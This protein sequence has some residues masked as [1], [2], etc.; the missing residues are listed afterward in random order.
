M[1]D[2]IRAA[3]GCR[4]EDIYSLEEQVLGELIEGRYKLL[5]KIGVGSMGAVFEAESLITKIKVAIKLINPSLQN[6]HQFRARFERE[7]FVAENLNSPYCAE[8]LEFG[9]CEDGRLFL[10]MELLKG[11]SIDA[12]LKR[13]RTFGVGKALYFT[14]QVLKGLVA[15]HSAGFIH[16]DIKPENIFIHKKEDGQDI[17]KIVDFGIAK[18]INTRPETN[19]QLTK[20]GLVLGTPYYIAPDWML[21]DDPDERTD[22]YSLTVSLFEMLTGAPP[23]HDTD[24][25][26]IMSRHLLRNRPA[27]AEINPTLEYPPELEAF[28]RKGWSLNRDDR[29][30]SAEEMGS[31][32]DVL[33][34]DMGL[35]EDDI[36]NSLSES[37]SS[38]GT[39][40]KIKE[41]A[42]TTSGLFDFATLQGV[43]SVG[44]LGLLSVLVFGFLFS[45]CNVDDSVSRQEGV[46][47]WADK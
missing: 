19:E 7:A 24:N 20:V 12:L 2:T 36:R 44:C 15:M 37:K 29:Y 31:A 42:N 11:E 18:P 13:E 34:G 9:E 1:R 35:N 43:L 38:F 21:H 17:A 16:R 23:I 39:A 32:I 6:Q 46:D 30:Q 28:V 47:W 40:K 33:M 8:V 22:M 26:R 4:F 3:A 25:K 5:Q 10:V 45:T 14:K 27:L 41:R